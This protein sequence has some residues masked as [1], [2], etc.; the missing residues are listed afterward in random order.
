MAMFADATTMGG[1]KVTEAQVRYLSGEAVPDPSSPGLNLPQLVAVSKKLHISLQNRT[2]S[3]GDTV[4]AYVEKNQKVIA[5][6]WYAGIGGTP[7][8]HAVLLQALRDGKFLMNDPMKTAAEWRDADQVISAM[9]EFA[10]RTGLNTGLRFAVG[11]QVQKMGVG[12]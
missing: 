1:L 8:G 6:L 10:T 12:Q 11:R 3:G 2:G 7:I 5:Q 9:K 4:K